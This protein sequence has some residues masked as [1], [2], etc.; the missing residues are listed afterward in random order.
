MLLDEYVKYV[1]SLWEWYDKPRITQWEI[2]ERK[3]RIW[4]EYKWLNQKWFDN[5][6]IIARTSILYDRAKFQNLFYK[7]S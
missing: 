6:S 5:L 2:E 7:K 3:L 4:I 1:D